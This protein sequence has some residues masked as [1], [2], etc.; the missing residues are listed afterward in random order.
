MSDSISHAPASPRPSRRGARIG[1]AAAVV[2]GL[3]VSTG[4]VF[5]ASSAAFSATTE[6]T[7]NNWT[8]GTVRLSDDDANA[9]I[10]NFGNS[11]PGDSVT[12]C[13][14][15]KSEG[16]LNAAVKFYATQGTTFDP[17]LASAITVTITQGTGSSWT[18]APACTGFV[19]LASGPTVYSG[20]LAGLVGSSNSWSTGIATSNPWTPAG[21][22]NETRTYKFELALPSNAGNDTAGK[23][24]QASF[25]W[26]SQN[27]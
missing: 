6:N 14:V 27:T 1:L 21:G 26:E 13:I 9:A 22:S 4:V 20:T 19:A 17:T 2:A 8:T 11:K 5:Q 18:A 16:S 10:F 24:V 25:V 23:T 12:R 7:N 15:V 3:S